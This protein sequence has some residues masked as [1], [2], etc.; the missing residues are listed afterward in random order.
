MKF[1]L[2]ASLA[3]KWVVTEADS[4]EAWRF[5]DYFGEDLH[6][7]DTLHVEVMGIIVRLAN[8]RLIK[9]DDALDRLIWWVR[10]WGKG[11]IQAHRVTPELVQ[12]AGKLAIAFGHPIKDC[13]YLALADRLG[14]PL[15]TCDVKFRD[16]V[17]DPARV[18]LLAELV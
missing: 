8:D 13:V 12:A 18:R 14:C 17:A 4:H 3:G 1:V 10:T 16:R 11:A 7:P 2:D 6:A 15:A 9:R 5:A